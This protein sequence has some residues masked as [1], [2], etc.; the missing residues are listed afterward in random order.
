MFGKGVAPVPRKSP[1][2]AR[3][4]KFSRIWCHDL[5]QAAKTRKMIGHGAGCIDQYI[6]KFNQ[7][8][9]P[10][11]DQW[12]AIICPR[13][14]VGQKTR[15]AERPQA[16]MQCS[17]RSLVFNLN[18]NLVATVKRFLSNAPNRCVSGQAAILWQN[19]EI[20]FCHRTPARSRRY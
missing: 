6:V 19:V 11:Y 1:C 16:V 20:N 8:I 2:F 18:K 14:G 4:L 13:D 12:F 3:G 7:R 17:G 5:R 9:V 10:S 15:F